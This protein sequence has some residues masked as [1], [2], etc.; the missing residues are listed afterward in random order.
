MRGAL[1]F[2]SE[3]QQMQMFIIK[4]DELEIISPCFF[5]NNEKQININLSKDKLVLYEKV[6]GIRHLVNSVYDKLDI[7]IKY[8]G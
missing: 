7:S 6:K 2:V 3:D 5:K 4:S 8:G 1:K